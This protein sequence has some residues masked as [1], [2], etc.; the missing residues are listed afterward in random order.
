MKSLSRLPAIAGFCL[1]IC[2]V[3]SPTALAG[4]ATMPAVNSALPTSEAGGTPP[5]DFP[6]P[7]P[8]RPFL[9]LAG[10]SQQASPD[11]VLALVS[12]NV[13]TLG[14]QGEHQ[15]EFLILLR[16]YVVQARELAGLADSEGVIR[17]SGCDDAKPLLRV[18]GYRPAPDCGQR[19]TT[20]LTADAERA[21]LTIDSGFPLTELEQTLQGG[22]AFAFSFSATRVPVLFAEGDWTTASRKNR[23][24]QSRDLLDTILNDHAVARLYWALSKMD[25]ETRSYLR[26]N[27]GI[28]KLLA[29]AALLDFYGGRLCIRDGQ[30]R[31][32]GGAATETAWEDL[33]GASPANPADFVPR[34]LLKDK[35]WLAA[36]FDVLSGV[37]GSQQAYFVEPHR[38]RRFY[39]ALRV[40]SQSVT[41][42]TGV[43]RPAP[44]LLLLV[45][46]L[47]LDPGGE[48]VVP[49]GVE[50]W[51]ETLLRNKSA[52]HASRDRRQ[53][54]VVKTPEDLLEA[55]FA[56]SR[57]ASDTGPLQAYLALAEL[58]SRRSAD[59]RLSADAVRAMTLRFTDYSDQYRIFSE[60]PE[61]S[62]ASILLFLNVAEQLG[63]ISSP[64]RG[65]AF[66][67]MQANIG[68]WQIL[69]RQGEISSAELDNSWQNVIR[70]FAKVRTSVQL[71]DAGHSSLGQLFR[72]LPD[73]AVAS[74]DE[75]IEALA[76]PPQSTPE[77]KKIHR[78][79]AA[80]IRS[81]LDAQ[82]LVSLDT[83]LT[84][85][86][87]LGEKAKGKEPEEYQ[88]R[89]ADELREFEKPQAIFTS[90]ERAEW[91]ERVYS[92]R[93]TDVQMRSTVAGTLQS[94]KATRTQIEDA[95]GQLASFLR[96]T[97]VGLNYAYYEP[98][99]AQVLHNN[100]LFVRSHDFAAETVEGIK[101][102]W[103]APQMFGAGD[104]AGG[105][106][107]FVGSLADLPYALADLEQDF[108][109]PRNVQALIWKELVPGLLTSAVLP[110]WWNVTPAELHAVTLYQ[111]T[112]EELLSASSTDEQLRGKVMTILSDRVL[113]QRSEQIEQA[114]RGGHVAEILP[115][116]MPADTFYLTAEFERR[117]PG[118]SASWG[119]ASQELQSLRQ[120]H[121]DQVNWQRLSQDFGV[122]H[123]TLGHTYAR[124]LLNVPPLPAFSGYAS[125]LLAESWDSSNL[126]WARLA[127]EAGYSPV[128]LNRLVPELTQHMVERTFGSDLED[129]PAILRAL[130]ET[131]EDFRKGKIASLSD[132]GN[133]QP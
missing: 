24:E 71:Y 121:P 84:L 67:I 127:D 92:T 28:R 88:L 96:D 50:V 33:T 52:E 116:M 41:A 98:P 99:G 10:V 82:R 109:A 124:E 95:R 27:V 97:L 25:P 62:D 86:D 39:T 80:R 72:A 65:N 91:A 26:Q 54:I 21:F 36:Y 94:A 44:W 30:V 47:Q 125:R 113:P 38:L 106:A 66:G 90:S 87:A 119:A 32:P 68:M 75:I 45:S 77:G 73:H 79:L 120:Q 34:L 3:L 131:G 6:I 17:V 58:D 70:P 7:G 117:Y 40:P 128:A 20:L 105:G 78:E 18:L 59:H 22:P 100:P 85:G 130:R 74:Q 101:N 81:V 9:R 126:Y 133:P 19:G 35:G 111:R 14:Y 8:L 49:G 48:P 89:K 43:F 102:V 107:H 13:E 29:Y 53:H 51:Q 2:M 103:Q 23:K 16:R 112:G 1:S 15:T 4:G 55:M 60:F 5:A 132:T 108:I 104:P 129:W 37:G 63:K 122:P 115:K 83:L 118:D 76:G 93:H 123:P 110:R 46:R 11:D 12:W 61:L 69:A 114:M 56:M 64:V 42:T 31:V 57:G